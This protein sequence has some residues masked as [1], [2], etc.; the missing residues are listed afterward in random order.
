MRKNL[1]MV[2][3]LVAE[4]LIG[5]VIL[6]LTDAPAIRAFHDA[7]RTK[8]SLLAQHPADYQ[9]VSLGELNMETGV[10]VASD[11]YIVVATGQSWLEFTTSI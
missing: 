9:L 2:Y 4:T 7:L 11:G 3:D 5:S 6:E 8:E 10:M 1:Y